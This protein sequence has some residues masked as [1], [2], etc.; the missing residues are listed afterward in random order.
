MLV[1]QPMMSGC[2]T[3]P[4][5]ILAPGKWDSRQFAPTM[6]WIS[7]D[8]NAVSRDSSEYLNGL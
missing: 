7:E 4:E 2:L 8:A 5:P 1:R 6:T 3:N